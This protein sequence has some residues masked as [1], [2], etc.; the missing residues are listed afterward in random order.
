MGNNLSVRVVI[1]L[2]FLKPQLGSIWTAKCVLVQTTL[3][4]FQANRQADEVWQCY[5]EVLSSILKGIPIW[6][7]ILYRNDSVKKLEFSNLKLKKTFNLIPT[8]V[9]LSKGKTDCDKY[10]CLDIKS[11]LLSAFPRWHC[12]WAMYFINMSLI[13]ICRK[14]TCWETWLFS[15]HH[16]QSWLLPLGLPLLLTNIT[17]SSKSAW[18]WVSLMER[19]ELFSRWSH[20]CSESCLGAWPQPQDL[21]RFGTGAAVAWSMLWSLQQS[22][23]PCTIGFAG[24]CS[25]S[26]VESHMMD[27]LYNLV[28]WTL[29]V[30]TYI[31]CASCMLWSLLLSRIKHNNIALT[32]ST[33]S[34]NTVYL[35][36]IWAFG[37]CWSSDGLQASCL[38]VKLPVCCVLKLSFTSVA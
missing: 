36:C 6:M 28:S 17:F 21:P 8:A 5:T 14:K 15:L 25:S 31:M 3:F 10:S 13:S 2:L 7:V 23:E 9:I 26:A 27:L 12:C 29:H 16:Y 30:Q 18:D 35:N 20:A 4:L 22:P 33:D 37:H 38:P 11:S 19:P 1:Y 24:E 32:R 34:V